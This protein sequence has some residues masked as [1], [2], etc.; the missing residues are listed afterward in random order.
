[1]LHQREPLLPCNFHGRTNKLLDGSA[2]GKVSQRLVEVRR[3][4]RC[5]PRKMIISMRR[6]REREG[7]SI[8]SIEREREGRREEG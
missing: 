5:V 2:V 4:R 7:G 8:G 6:G 3:G 1:M